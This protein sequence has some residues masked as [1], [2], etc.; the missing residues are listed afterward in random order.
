MTYRN[1]RETTVI[2][3]QQDGVG[4]GHS[5]MATILETQ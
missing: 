1:T 4:H 3:L 2:L 5:R